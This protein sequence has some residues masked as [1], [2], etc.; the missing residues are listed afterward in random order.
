MPRIDIIRESAI[1]RTG[2]VAQV[3]G[4]FDMSAAKKSCEKWS[5]DFDLPDEW[6]I[7]VIVGPSGCGKTTFAREVFSQ[8]L[9]E[10][11]EWA[12]DKSVL[13]GF[14]ED[15]SIKDIVRLLSSVGFSSTPSWL[16]P[17]RV[18]STGE[19]F[20]VNVARALAESEDITVID[21][22]T[23]VVDRT[24][25]QVGSAAVA[26]A[27][28]RRGQKFIAVTCHY[29]VLDW[30]EP[31]WVLQPHLNE[32]QRGSH[33]RPPI[34]LT[35]RRVHRSAWE[36]FRKHHYL[37]TSIHNAAQCFCA[38]IGDVPVAFSAWIHFPAKFSAKRGHRLV[39]LP[40][41]QGVGIGYT[42]EDYTASAWTALGHRAL[43]TTSHPAMIGQRNRNPAWKMTAKPRRNRRSKG[44]KMALTFRNTC[45]SQRYVASFRYVGKPLD[46]EL[47][48]RLVG[49]VK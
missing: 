24:V 12:Q 7:G 15:M 48:A 38:F 34:E 10:G 36:L 30:L 19:Q 25:A 17:F 31:D 46:R 3:E 39:T 2:R 42:L 32:M 45:A 21:E 43:S 13:D 37:D 33:R 9:C 20:R 40:D 35:I 29:D 14:P 6:S 49:A 1:E 11:F 18:L 47:A 28:R 5:I 4:M 41:Y 8:E 44:S 22:F 26:K 27:V 16:R 23:S